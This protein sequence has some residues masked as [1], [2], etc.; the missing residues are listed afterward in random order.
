MGVKV[1]RHSGSDQHM[2]QPQQVDHS[3]KY[4]EY[5]RT[6]NPPGNGSNNW[7][8]HQSQRS[9]RNDGSYGGPQYSNQE[10]SKREGQHMPRN[11]PQYHG[12]QHNY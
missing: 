11:N 7:N 4:Q 10:M 12:E 9:T 5:L 2:Q 6:Q 3:Q 8:P 1:N